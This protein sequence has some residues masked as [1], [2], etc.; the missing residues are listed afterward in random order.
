MKKLIPFALSAALL[1][2]GCGDTSKVDELINSSTAQTV[3]LN[4][5]DEAIAKLAEDTAEDYWANKETSPVPQTTKIDEAE[6]KNGDIDIDLTGLNANMLYAQVYEMTSD[7][8]KYEGKTVRANGTFAYTAD[9]NTGGEYFAVF[10]ADAAACCSQGLEFRREGEFSYPADYPEIG[11]PIVVT[12]TFR[13]YKEGVFTYCE[14]A[15]AT[16]EVENA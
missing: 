5:T 16:M 11:E 6:L 1:L 2:A 14:L 15:D 4:K 8:E 12:G 3:T 10:I 13:T 9:P 7:P